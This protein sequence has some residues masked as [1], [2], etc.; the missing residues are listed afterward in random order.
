MFGN[1]NEATHTFTF[2]VTI[3]DY[4]IASDQSSAVNMD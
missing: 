3:G 4:S 2:T 1:N